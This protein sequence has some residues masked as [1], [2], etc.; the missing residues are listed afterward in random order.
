MT[1]RIRLQN[2][3]SPKKKGPKQ[4]CKGK[5]QPQSHHSGPHYSCTK[6]PHSKLNP[7]ENLLYSLKSP[8]QQLYSFCVCMATPYHH[9]ST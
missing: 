2:L 4:E 5:T 1:R 9:S 6:F 3:T 7:W 8:L